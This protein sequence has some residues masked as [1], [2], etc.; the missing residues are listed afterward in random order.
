MI[1]HLF[2]KIFKFQAKNLHLVEICT[3][4]IE[5]SALMDQN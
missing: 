2:K 3:L 1:K 5:N 4:L